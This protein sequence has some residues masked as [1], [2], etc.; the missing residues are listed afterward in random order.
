M[1]ERNSVGSILI[2]IV[3]FLILWQ[4]ASWI[5]NQPILP[6]PIV[7]LPIFFRLMPGDLGIDFLYSTYRVLAAIVASTLIAVPIGLILGQMPG[8]DRFFNPLIAIT[9]PVPKIVLMPVIYVLIGISDFSK[10]FLIGL[11]LF[12][13][14]L[15]VVRD[16]AATLRPE[17]IFSVRSLGAGGRALLRYVY[18]PA[19]LPVIVTSLRISASLAIAI[20]F[21]VE[22]SLT[23][24]GLGYFIIV[25]TYQVLR[26]PEMYAG[27]LAMS[28]LGSLLYFSLDWLERRINR[29]LYTS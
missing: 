28:L 19:S 20:L 10:I 22:Q 13:Q 4:I 26:Y 29:Y 27:I 6:S 14:I 11:I 9:Y 8:L 25:K 16:K 15:V 18:F 1:K 17:L 2:G 5:V 7:V 3:M 21:I 23:T 12:F 24:H